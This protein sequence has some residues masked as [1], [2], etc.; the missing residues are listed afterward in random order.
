MRLSLFARNLEVGY[1]SS[2]FP[3]LDYAET[4]SVCSRYLSATNRSYIASHADA[5]KHE[6]LVADEG[7]DR[8]YDDIIEIDLSKLEPHINGPFTPD[9]SHPLSEFR[10]RVTESSWPVNLSCSLVGSCTNISYEDLVKV[11]SLVTQ[12]RDACLVNVKTPFLV[13][14]GSEQI[15]AT[16]EACGIL[17]DLR[18]AGA[19]VLS[20]SCGPCVGHW[21]RTDVDVAGAEKNSVISSFNRNF[22]G[23]HDSNPA[24]HSFVTSP[25]LATTFAYAGKLTFNPTTD[26]PPIP[27]SSAAAGGSA[28]PGS[29][30]GSGERAL[31]RSMLGNYSTR[32][33]LLRGTWSLHPVAENAGTP[34]LIVAIR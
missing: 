5:F 23:R 3:P 4:N 13:A 25:E 28:F 22:T 32:A 31:L 27:S 34:S 9:L 26:S 8:Y 12:A 30:G 16:A 29:C 17:G 2:C 24:T 19:I 33:P 18:E 6:H 21:D 15:R 1:Y 14:P 7:S 10:H 20:N 11:H